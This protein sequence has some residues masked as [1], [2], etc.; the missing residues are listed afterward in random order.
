MIFDNGKRADCI[1]LIIPEKEN[2]YEIDIH[3]AAVTFNDVGYGD[4]TY[5]THYS[6]GNSV[7]SIPLTEGQT[8]RA[9]YRKNNGSIEFN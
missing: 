5:L 8:L 4:A 9:T 1:C 6:S 7:W 3:A 2:D